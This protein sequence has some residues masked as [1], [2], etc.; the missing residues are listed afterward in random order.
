MER[1]RVAAELQA[2]A[3]A[4]A[5]EEARRQQRATVDALVAQGTP[6]A[7]AEAERIAA[8]TPV[9]V[10]VPRQAIEAQLPQTP[11]GRSSK[12]VYRYEVVDLAKCLRAISESPILLAL[13][14]VQ[15]NFTK[16]KAKPVQIAGVKVS[17]DYETSNRGK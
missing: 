3:D 17:E 16:V 9:A 14:G 11:A 6:E 15:L 8:E 7:T 12:K 13:I 4:E 5:A 10:A 1:N 2:K